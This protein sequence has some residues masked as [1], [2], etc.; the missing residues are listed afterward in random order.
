MDQYTIRE[1]EPT[2]RTI[3]V[4]NI[5]GLA[6]LVVGLIVYGGIWSAATGASSAT[7]D[8]WHLLI[9]VLATFGLMILHE[10]VHGIAIAAFGGTPVYGATIV[11]KALPAF[12]CTSHGTRFT[13]A[14]FT[15][16]ALAPAVVIGIGTAV[17]I[18][19]L[20]AGWLVVPAAIHLGGCVGDFAMTIIA[21]R[22]PRE[23][24]IEDL[25]SGMRLYLPAEPTVP[26][27]T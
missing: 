18:A 27:T 7:F 24:R 11:G 12:Y 14:Q 23:S 26:T 22:L 8:A 21:A 15:T 25:K 6:M 19:A 13:K 16:I 1:W 5:S 3:A 20:P 4:L 9:A 10:G 17:A 2:G